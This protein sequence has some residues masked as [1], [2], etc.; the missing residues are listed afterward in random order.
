MVEEEGR[1]ND[2]EA[3][4][5]EIPEER[6]I[7]RDPSESEAASKPLEKSTAEVAK[8]T[9][10][11]PQQKLKQKRGENLGPRRSR[12]LLA[13]VEEEGRVNDPEGERIE[14]PE[15]RD[16]IRDPSEKSPAEAD[17]ET[18]LIPPVLI[19]SEKSTVEAVNETKRIAAISK[20]SNFHNKT[21]LVDD[22]SFEAALSMAVDSH[23][24]EI[25]NDPPVATAICFSAQE[26]EVACSPHTKRKVPDSDTLSNEKL[27]AV[28]FSSPLR[29]PSPSHYVLPSLEPLDP[30]L[31][32]L[33]DR[34]ISEEVAE[35]K[36]E[37][38]LSQGLS[39]ST[40]N[41]SPALISETC[42]EEIGDIFRSFQTRTGASLSPFSVW[43]PNIRQ[44]YVNRACYLSHA[45]METNRMI[46]H[47][48]NLL[49]QPMTET[50]KAK[51]EIDEL[52]SVNLP[53]RLE[54]PKTFESS[55]EDMKKTLAANAQR[56]RIANAERDSAK[57]DALRL[58]AELE[59]ATAL[60]EEASHKSDFLVKTRA[61]EIAEAE[62]NAR[63]EI[64][65]FGRQLIQSIVKFI[66][67]EEV[68]TKLQTDR[69]EL[70]SNLDLI[71]ELENGRVSFE[72]ERR[73]VTAEF[74][75]VE[76]ELSSAS[77][78]TLDLKQFS[79]V[80][81]DSS[82]QF[83]IGEGSRPSEGSPEVEERS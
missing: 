50:A 52:K 53:D 80:F 41:P 11:Q 38:P 1:V 21:L 65:S 18:V 39:V 33:S 72:N 76:S 46:F 43:R 73:E 83:E 67:D 59:K 77:R 32:L 13:M 55:F 4:R 2:P 57:S 62:H 20:V 25:S 29:A 22:G 17:N 16:I 49:Y 81:G 74:A 44:M 26:R 58:K 12:R 14:I 8:E 30:E 54:Q 3:E 28:R 35:L 42:R 47:Y 45:F 75:V 56:L 48:E 34:A 36:S 24:A 63:E 23:G 70:K 7:I 40:Q 15:E 69:P 6:D 64:R 9:V 5:I 19:P 78:P 31:P 82:S 51:K 27:K 37:V 79:L 71:E 68:W 60:S 10:P 66:K 61:P